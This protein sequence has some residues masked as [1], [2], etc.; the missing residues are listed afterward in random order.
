MDKLQFPNIGIKRVIA[1]VAVLVLVFMTIWA[2]LRNE[3]EYL[4]MLI[5]FWIG[6]PNWYFSR[7]AILN[8]PGTSGETKNNSPP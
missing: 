3:K 7:S 5:P 6:I 2:A 4:L 1:L 8:N